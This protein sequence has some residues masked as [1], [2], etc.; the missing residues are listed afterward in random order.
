MSDE[1]SFHTTFYGSNL[2]MPDS[3]TFMRRAI[4][5]A[6]EGMLAR[7]GGPFGAVVVRS[8]EIIGQGQNL[9]LASSDPTAHAEIVAIRS[10]CQ[11][12]GSYSLSG[13]EL[14]TSCEPC[15]MCLGAILWSR[16]SVV[17]YAAS[18]T[19]ASTIGFD[20]AL[21]YEQFGLAP[22]RRTIPM[23]QLLQDQSIKVFH[24]FSSLADRTIY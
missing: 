12:L 4:E 15:P 10:A 14:F 7:S 11:S 17:Y 2:S 19:D 21:F 20:D 18:R 3:L 13:C 23:K 1:P 6:R 22:E 8:G 5:L 24:E 16:L 9:V